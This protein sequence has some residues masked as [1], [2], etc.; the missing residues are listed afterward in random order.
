MSTDNRPVS[1]FP[2]RG[3]EMLCISVDFNISL[4]LKDARR[5]R[6]VWISQSQILL[7]I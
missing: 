3:D 4:S 1:M 7:F 6:V 5:P 2:P